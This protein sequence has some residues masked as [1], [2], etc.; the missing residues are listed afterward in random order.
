MG[1]RGRIE[2]LARYWLAA[3]VALWVCALPVWIRL[4]SLPALLGSLT[5]A[6]KSRTHAGALNLDETVAIVARVCRWRL[7]RSRPFPRS[8]LRQS[9]AL[10]RVLTRMGYPVMIHFGVQTRGP[11]FLGHSWVTLNGRPLAEAESPRRF[12]SV[13]SYGLPIDQT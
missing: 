2:K 10:F 1:H 3:Q 11:A 7:F 13:Y 8:C 12:T 6:R 5:A 9:L 4:L